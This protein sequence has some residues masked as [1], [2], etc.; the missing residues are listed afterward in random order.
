MG[1]YED[2]AP[3]KK[4]YSSPT[5][6]SAKRG[7]HLLT[8]KSLICKNSSMIDLHFLSISSSDSK[9]FSCA[10]AGGASGLAGRNLRKTKTFGEGKSVSFSEMTFW[11]QKSAEQGVFP[12]P[13]SGTGHF[14]LGYISPVWTLNISVHQPSCR[15]IAGS[16]TGCNTFK[17][18]YQL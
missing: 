13:S 8:L 1:A 14:Y 3:G 5:D 16:D 6:F 4:T 2:T 7:F 12:I 15:N 17:A 11:K 18:L 9:G 10:G